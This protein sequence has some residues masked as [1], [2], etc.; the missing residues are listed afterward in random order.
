MEC[1]ATCKNGCLS[2]NWFDERRLIEN[3][4]R[5]R[6]N[7]LSKTD[8]GVYIC[9][10]TDYYGTTNKS[11]DLNVLCRYFCSNHKLCMDLL[12]L[13]SFTVCNFFSITDGPGNVNIT[14]TSDRNNLIEGQGNVILTCYADCNPTCFYYFYKNSRYK[15][16]RYYGSKYVVKYRGNSGR[17]SCSAEN[18]VAESPT[19]SSN[20]VDIYIQCKFPS[21]HLFS[22]CLLTCHSVNT[23]ITSFKIKLHVAYMHMLT[24]S[25]HVHLKR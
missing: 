19:N 8:H 22:S 5:L 6:F 4:E 21:P 13:I 1:S 15:K 16:F 9:A 3:G 2:Y 25:I 12:F 20:S 7:N 14:Y 17:Y 24:T 10:V 11:Q 18:S 23:V